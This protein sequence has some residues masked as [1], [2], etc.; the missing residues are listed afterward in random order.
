MDYDK[1]DDPNFDPFAT[2]KA[3]QNSPPSTPATFDAT[4]PQVHKPEPIKADSPL[5]I[6]DL[7]TNV[8]ESSPPEVDDAPP[9]LEPPKK[10]PPVLGK[11]RKPLRK[12]V[13]KPRAKAPEPIVDPADPAP[14]TGAYSADFDKFDDPNYNP[15]ETKKAMQNSP[16]ISP[17]PKSSGA[18]NID[19]DKFDDPNFNPFETKKAMQNS[20]TPDQQPAPVKDDKFDDPNFNP[21]ETKVKMQNSPPPSPHPS[22]SARPLTPPGMPDEKF[23]DPNFNPFET[24][25]KMSNSPTPPTTTVDYD[26]Y[27]DPNF[28]PFATKVKMQNSPPASPRPERLSVTNDAEK[29]DDP[30][31]NPFET[32][33]K[34][35]SSPTPEEQDT[36][37]ANQLSPQQLNKTHDVE[38]TLSPNVTMT[39]KSLNSTTTESDHFVS[40]DEDENADEN[41]DENHDPN[42]TVDMG[43]HRSTFSGKKSL[44][45]A[46]AFVQQVSGERVKYTSKDMEV[47][48]REARV[49]NDSTRE[50]L[51]QMRLICSQYEETIV[52][53]QQM[54]L[55]ELAKKD[56]ELSRAIDD[57]DSLQ[58]DVTA[59][60]KSFTDLHSRFTRLRSTLDNMRKNEETLKESIKQYESRLKQE[61]GRYQVLKKSSYELV[62][63][64][65]AEIEQ[66]ESN[67]AKENATLQVE[68]KRLRLQNQSL[69]SQVDRKDTENK[70]LTQICDEL[71]ASAHR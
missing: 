44:E 69:E 15:F 37:P 54:Q 62:T 9:E 57:R 47:I 65:N 50:E 17:V 34:M 13:V 28:N 22:A 18:Y 32:K 12:K 48:R 64:A 7:S 66:V 16:P 14:S 56:K 33:A 8:D 11:N 21:F 58:D 53:L 49:D 63:R 36:S 71:I 42:V 10:K 46:T 24:K 70:E 61:Q 27:D 1:F 40:A 4:P 6:A 52:K 31:F 20:P 39:T 38:S 67:T 45:N 55:T 60:D 3:M 23:E 19:Y 35:R 68:L 29:F 41:G 25:A 59:L 5:N 43:P 2:K 51:G 26:Q 30:N